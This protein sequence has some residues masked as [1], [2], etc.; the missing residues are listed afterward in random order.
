METRAVYRVDPVPGGVSGETKRCCTCKL[1]KPVEQFYYKNRAQGLR[2]PY[3]KACKALYNA[4][5]YGK[6]R[7][8]QLADVK[9]TK[10][11]RSAAALAL[12]ASAKDNPCTDCGERLPPCAMDFD[13]VRGEKVANI[14]KMVNEGPSL[15]RL[16]EELD[17]CELVCSNCHRIRTLRRGQRWGKTKG[18]PG[19]I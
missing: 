8:K 15:S 13:H 2:Q 6:N 10:K 3:C 16:Q 17:K 19:R 14:S 5:W 12:V 11:Q 1:I 18:A 9:R 4:Q 7:E